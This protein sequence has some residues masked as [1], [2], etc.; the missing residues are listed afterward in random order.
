[1]H[2]R[3]YVPPSQPDVHMLL[4]DEILGGICPTFGFGGIVLI[5]EVAVEEDVS[6]VRNHQGLT[7]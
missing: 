3:R 6:A 5:G 2:L 1:M 7:E 4:F